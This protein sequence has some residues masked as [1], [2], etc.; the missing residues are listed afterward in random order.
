MQSRQRFTFQSGSRFNGNCRAELP[1]Q[2]TDTASTR[3]HRVSHGES[4]SYGQYVTGGVLIPVVQNLA[5]GARPLAN[6]DRQALGNMSHQA[7]HNLLLSVPASAA[8]LAARQGSLRFGQFIKALREMPGVRDAFAV[9]QGGETMDARINPDSGI[10]G[11]I[12]GGIRRGQSRDRFVQNEGDMIPTIG[13]LGYRRCGRVTG[14]SAAP[15]NR[16]A[17]DPS[18]RE[19]PGIGVPFEGAFGV[20]RRLMSVPLFLEGGLEIAKGLLCRHAGDFIQPGILRLFFE[21][22]QRRGSFFVG[23]LLSTCESVCSESERPVVNESAG[24]KHP[25]KFACLEWRGVEPE[26][27]PIPKFHW[28]NIHLVRSA[29][30]P[31]RKEARVFL[32]MAK[33]KGL[34]TAIS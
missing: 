13:R 9:R 27:E 2:R 17:T 20:L 26:P 23:D 25:G 10:D 18:H 33:A 14:E 5:R 19:R 29:D 16:K 24:S 12:D 11:G 1:R 31:P 28:N 22:S 7:G 21:K 3:S 30:K 32:P 8:F 15:A 6:M 4:M 34:Q